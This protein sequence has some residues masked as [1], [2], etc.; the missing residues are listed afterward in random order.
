MNTELETQHIEAGAHTGTMCPGLYDLEFL[1]SYQGMN[2]G[3][4]Y[5]HGSGFLPVIPITLYPSLSS[6]AAVKET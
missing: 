6:W 1:P 2:H 4:T 3:I 5:H